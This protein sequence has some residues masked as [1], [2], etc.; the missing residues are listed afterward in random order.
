MLCTQLTGKFRTLDK[1]QSV[2]YMGK[3]KDPP[4]LHWGCEPGAA[5]L[6]SKQQNVSNVS[7]N[8]ITRNRA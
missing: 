6:E 2:Q 4:A 8:S 3:N 7:S 1:K 5:I